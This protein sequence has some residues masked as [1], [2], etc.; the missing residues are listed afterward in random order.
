MLRRDP[1]ISVMWKPYNQKKKIYNIKANITDKNNTKYYMYLQPK[2]EFFKGC[3]V[4][5][6]NILIIEPSI[7]NIP[8]KSMTEEM[9]AHRDCND[10]IARDMLLE[11][12]V[13]PFFKALIK[14]WDSIKDSQA[15]YRIDSLKLSDFKATT[16]HIKNTK[17]GAFKLSN[18]CQANIYIKG[19]FNII[20]KNQDLTKPILSSMFE[21][22]T[23]SS[24]NLKIKTKIYYNLYSDH[25]NGSINLNSLLVD[26]KK[27]KK[28]AKEILTKI[29]KDKR[30]I[31]SYSNNFKKEFPK[32]MVV[33][34]G[35]AYEGRESNVQIDS[36]GDQAT[37]FEVIVNSPKKPV[38]LI[39]AA[40]KPSIW[41]IKWT[42]GTKIE[43]VYA[44][45]Y[46]KQIVLGVP[47]SIP[48]K[49]NT[50]ENRSKSGYFYLSDSTLKK[51][52]PLS[53]RVF[54]KNVKLAYLAKKD[55]KIHFGKPIAS[56]T[57]CILQR[58]GFYH[59]M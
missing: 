21:T 36:S 37:I 27:M 2:C 9:F 12:N 34:A 22:V 33:Y 28:A 24:G 54:S 35:G 18:S 16:N 41:N 1:K 39:L 8:I 19:D 49:N 6:D 4:G 15:T 46:H 25:N 20:F 50:H 43:A 45:G 55:G 11:K 17:T 13:T 5:L 26:M 40:Y 29:K 44:T 57:G 48:I 51:L 42:K 10:K 14:K 52:N 7:K 30:Y 32:D 31:Q 53:Q 3:Q 38:A 56:N 47:N 59:N 58:R 23:S